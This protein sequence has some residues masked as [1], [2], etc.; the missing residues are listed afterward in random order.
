MRFYAIL[1]VLMDPYKSLCV[2]VDS[3]GFLWLLRFF[4]GPFA[5]LFVLMGPYWSLFVFTSLSG[6]L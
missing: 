2:L 6:S 5:S 4:I 1:W 3:N